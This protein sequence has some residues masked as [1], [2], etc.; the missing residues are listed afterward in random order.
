VLDLLVRNGTIVDGTG[1][2]RH[3]G[4]VAVQDGRI[5]AVGTITDA[6]RHTIDADGLVVS[7]GFIDLHTHLDAQLF[8]DPLATPS[9]NHGFTTV[10]A[11]NCGFTL[12]PIVDDAHVDPLMRLMS[13]VEGMPLAA[14][15]SRVPFDWRS[16]GD[17]LARLDGAMGVNAGFLV[18]HSTLRRAVMGER[19]VEEAAT[20]DDVAAMAALLERCLAEGGV[21]FS[22]SWNPAQ[23]DHLG[24]PAPSRTASVSELVALSS[25]LQRYPFAALEFS[26]GV[27]FGDRETEVMIRMAAAAGRP[28]NWNVIQVRSPDIT[29]IQRQLRGSDDAAEY[30][31]S[32]VALMFP[33]S[34]ASWHTMRDG[35][36]Y[37]LLPE[38]AGV[39]HRPL[40]ER[41]QLLRDPAVRQRLAEGATRAQ[42]PFFRLLGSWD[43]QTIFA[44]YAP[45]NEGLVGKTLAEI[46]RARG[47]SPLEA[48]FD[49]ALAD[50]LRT[51]VQLPT[52][53]DRDELW[54]LRAELWNDPRTLLGG[55]DAGAH[56]DMLASQRYSTAFLAKAVRQRELLTL[57][58]A[59]RMLTTAPA[60]LYGLSD[61][62]RIE[63]GCMAD[64]VLF[65][66]QTVGH[67][68]MHA[69][70]DLPG[71]DMR[72]YVNPIGIHHVVVNGVEVL[73][74]DTPTGNLPGRVIRLP[75]S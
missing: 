4:D 5:V 63:A 11:G 40:A 47:V 1:A 20:D 10:F 18:G 44:T 33:D 34:T 7:P 48:Y 15:Q 14:L 68:P 32:L 3:A 22:S 26:P 28:L 56:L 62:G 51:Y 61:R 21:G 58:A 71:G 45:E 60:A 8:W 19:A 49:I 24:R 74:D 2:P 13:V 73:R 29:P 35:V 23:I 37:D 69:R 42:A 54:K 59:V 30:G 57:E 65:D 64:L 66:P 41:M 36:L 31:A 16:F 27:A 70:R 43:D 17:Y 12:A 75:G 52:V 67:G 39:M 53:D 25:V 55:S 6:A 72:I 38:W 9:T 46:G 50:E